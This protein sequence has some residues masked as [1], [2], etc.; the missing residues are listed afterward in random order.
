MIIHNGYN[1]TAKETLRKV[2]TER[3]DCPSS[4]VS[5]PKSS[6]CRFPNRS[7]QNK[8][9]PRNL[10]ACGSSHC[11][12]AIHQI[13]SPSLLLVWQFDADV[14]FLELLHRH[15]GGGGHHEVL[16]GLV[17]REGDHFADVLLVAQDHHQTIE[18]RGDASVRRRAVLEGFDHVT[19]TG[20][21]L[22]FRVARDLEGF[23]HDVGAV[24]P[25]RAA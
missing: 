23:V 11:Q 10:A 9:L 17:H 25:D 13:S 6:T 21:N 18:A 24:V 2:Y 20:I 7:P 22:L 3:P 1:I 19:K 5:L 4:D 8:K 16:G 14:Q 12:A 15:L